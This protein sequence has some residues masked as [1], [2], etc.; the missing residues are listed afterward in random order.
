MSDLELL[1]N[2]LV[3]HYLYIDETFSELYDSDKDIA[4]AID[5]IYKA[6]KAGELKKINPHLE[7]YLEQYYEAQTED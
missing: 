5:R 1:H 2:L 7:S 6:H 4:N 3:T